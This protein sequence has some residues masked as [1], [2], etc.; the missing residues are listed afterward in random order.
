V[1]GEQTLV[2]MRNGEQ[3]WNVES[4]QARHLCYRGLS[5]DGTLCN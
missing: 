2:T 3:G 1:A 5:S 4:A